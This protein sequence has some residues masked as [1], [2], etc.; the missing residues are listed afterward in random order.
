MAQ[1]NSL[2]A[3]SLRDGITTT[4][5]W[6]RSADEATRVEAF[7]RWAAKLLKV[8]TELDSDCSVSQ[9]FS[10]FEGGG[11]KP[12]EAAVARLVSVGRKVQSQNDDD[13]EKFLSLYDP[14]RN[15]SI[16][17]FWNLCRTSGNDNRA[18]IRFVVSS[19]E[20]GSFRNAISNRILKCVLSERIDIEEDEMR[21]RGLSL[22][23][24]HKYRTAARHSIWPDRE[25]ALKRNDIAG[26]RWK[27]FEPGVL[28]GFGKSD[29]SH[30]IEQEMTDI[31]FS[32]LIAWLK[33]LSEYTVW[34]KLSPLVVKLKEEFLQGWPNAGPAAP[35]T[36][37]TSQSPVAVALGTRGTKRLRTESIARRLG[38]TTP[39]GTA[40]CVPRTPME[41]GSGGK[42]RRN[43]QTAQQNDLDMQ[44][45]LADQTPPQTDS[46]Q[47]GTMHFRLD[48]Q[49]EHDGLP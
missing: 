8:R 48:N 16:K 2:E 4:V 22:P 29:I 45:P 17:Q 32:A 31:E 9:F 21:K 49:F 23:R 10:S 3:S 44:R 36:R 42:G 25:D 41:R 30:I 1:G 34:E 26:Q 20:S 6:L 28:I 11:K 5:Q 24:G 46:V 27:R 39:D 40:I 43:G 33:G 15:G 37:N 35:H 19:L 13:L 47:A 14:A 7:R 12:S 38:P 18:L